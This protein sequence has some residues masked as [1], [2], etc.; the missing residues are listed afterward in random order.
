MTSA[1]AFFAGFC[2]AEDDF[3]VGNYRPYDGSMGLDYIS[4]Y[5]RGFQEAVFNFLHKKYLI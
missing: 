1:N 5:I 4:G 2:A 3:L